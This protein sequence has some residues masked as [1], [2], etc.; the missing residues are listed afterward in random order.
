MSKKS[1]KTSQ[2]MYITATHTDESD[3]NYG[4]VRINNLRHRT[5]LYFGVPRP[6]EVHRWVLCNVRKALE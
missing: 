1:A 3:A 2:S 5:V 4:I 6:I